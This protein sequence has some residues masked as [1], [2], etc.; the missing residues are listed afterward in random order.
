MMS[1]NRGLN[2]LKTAGIIHLHSVPSTHRSRYLDLFMLEKEKDKLEKDSKKIEKRLKNNLNRLKE[3][4]SQIEEVL[5]DQLKAKRKSNI[6]T[7]GQSAAKV[8]K[9]QLNGQ[10]KWTTVKLGY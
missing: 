8:E 3:I 7:K 2:T 5:A 4:E 10:K 6:K 9:A 1:I